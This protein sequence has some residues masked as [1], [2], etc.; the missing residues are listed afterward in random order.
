MT[1]IVEAL[2][3]FLLILIRLTSFFLIAPLFSMKGIPTQFKIG[4]AALL[5]LIALGG[6]STDEIIALDAYY[7]LLIFKELAIGV[8][9]GFTAT[10]VLYT[11][12]IAGAFIDFQM[13][14][15]IANVIDPQTGAQ[16][17]IIGHFKYMMALLFLLSVNGHHLLLDGIMQSLM[18][19]PVERIDF[20]V[21]FDGTAEFITTLFSFIFLTALQ[22]AMPIVGALFLV[23]IALGILAKTVPQLNIFAVGLSVKIFVGFILLFLAM[24]VYFYLLQFLFE[25]MVTSMMDLMSLL[26]GTLSE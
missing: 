4:L 26:G 17:P 21:G 6:V 8:A 25:R 20:A 10:L 9:L 1:S 16:V 3:Y 19:F 12:Q 7:A 2:P 24:P 23:D 5:S 11:V 22:I 15:A 14:F 18:I 13:G